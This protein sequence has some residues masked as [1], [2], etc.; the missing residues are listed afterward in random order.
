MTAFIGRRE[1]IT[2]LGG[3][4]AW[5]LAARAQQAERVRHIGVLL[6]GDVDDPVWQARVGHVTLFLLDTD[7]SPN[8]AADRHITYRLYGGDRNTRLEQEIVLGVGGVRALAAMG[9]KP[10]VW[11]MNEGHAAFL[12]LERLRTIM[13][14][15][16]DLDSALEAVAS[17]TVFTTH[18]AVE[19][20]HDRFSRETIEPP[21]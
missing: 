10:T 12:V 1:F 20:G 7:V 8:R 6:P 3:A 9:L 4:A 14:T 21:G 13:R 2:L 17:D 15:G 11:H 5:P 18:T 16:V 19:A